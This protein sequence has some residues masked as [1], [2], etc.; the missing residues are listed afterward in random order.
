MNNHLQT[1]TLSAK[2]APYVPKSSATTTPS[3]T[4]V[5]G[6]AHTTHAPRVAPTVAHA[7]TVGPA[8]TPSVAKVEYPCECATLGKTC[9]N[10]FFLKGRIYECYAHRDDIK[11]GICR[12]CD[13]YEAQDRYFDFGF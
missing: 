7:P 11:G 6:S 8:N 3:P 2:A 1:S 9:N 13:Y 10:C 5:A 12:I 4:P